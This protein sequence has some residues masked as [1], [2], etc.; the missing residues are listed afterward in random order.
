VGG[1]KKRLQLNQLDEGLRNAQ[2]KVQ[3][4]CTQSGKKFF[5][6]NCYAILEMTRRLSLFT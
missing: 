6:K 1:F 4:K 2:K 3:Q 5:W